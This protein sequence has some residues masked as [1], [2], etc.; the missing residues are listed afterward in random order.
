M[1]LT[2]DAMCSFNSRAEWGEISSVLTCYEANVQS[3]NVKV[4]CYF[5]CK[6]T[7][8]EIAGDSKAGVVV[9]L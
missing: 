3:V 1:E 8:W 7:H 4:R 5:N 6:L 2:A 9:F